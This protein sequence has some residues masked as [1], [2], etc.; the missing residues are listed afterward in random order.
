MDW[1]ENYVNQ[2]CLYD[3]S[4]DSVFRTGT[5]VIDGRACSLCFHVADEAAHVALAERSKCCLLY[6][7]L[8]R[9]ATGETREVCAVVTAGSTASLYAGRNGI[10]YDCA[11]ND[12]DAVVSKVVEAQVSLKEAFWAPWAKIAG[13]IS[14][15]CKKFLSA[16]QDAAVA[17]VGAAAT[18]AATPPAA[19]AAAPAPNGAALASS[20]AAIGIGIGFVGAACGGLLSILTKTPAWQTLLGVLAIILLVSLVQYLRAS[21]LPKG[22]VFRNV[23]TIM[24][25]STFPAQIFATLFDAAGGGRYLSFQILFVIIFFVYQLFAFRAVMNKVCPQP[26]RKDDDFDDSDF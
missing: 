21:T 17:K 13:T 7:K 2:A 12:W 11:G 6:V 16:K 22:I 5:L 8:S 10:F 3:A 9:K 14:E 18:A 4:R 19:P 1:L 23:L 25:Y 15:Q 26:E 20:V 24:V